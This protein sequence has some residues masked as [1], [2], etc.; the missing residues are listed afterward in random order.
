MASLGLD[1]LHRAARERR[2][3]CRRRRHDRGRRPATD[4]APL[5]R[6]QSRARRDRSARPTDEPG[7]GLRA[8]GA[9][10]V[11]VTSSRG[12]APAGVETIVLPAVDGV[13]APRDDRRPRC[14]ASASRASWSKAAR[15]R[16]RPS[17]TPARSTGC[18]SSSPARSSARGVTG[19]DLRPLDRLGDALKPRDR[20]LPP[21]WRATSCSIATCASKRGHKSVG[22]EESP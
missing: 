9:R 21:G 14:I 13:I 15:E 16:F 2:R 22:D 17:S 1:H 12:A 3:R 7:A 18:I 8:D 10:R 4:R 5:R 19:L 11:L 6:P 20:D